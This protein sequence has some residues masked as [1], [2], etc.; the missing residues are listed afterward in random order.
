MEVCRRYG[1]LSRFFVS[2]KPTKVFLDIL[3]NQVTDV[4]FLIS[5]L[6]KFIEFDELR[7]CPNVRFL[8]P[9]VPVDVDLSDEADG[10]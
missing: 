1:F 10:V 6:L 5:S 4:T 7:F 3:T 9:S 2:V 8:V